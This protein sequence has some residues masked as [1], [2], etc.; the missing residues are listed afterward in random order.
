MLTALEAL[1]CG[2]ERLGGNSLRVRAASAAALP[3]KSA[4]LFLSNAG[5][6]MRPLTAA[7]ACWRRQG[8]TFELR[9]IAR[10]H[11][12]PIG[13]LVDGL[14][15]LGCQWTTSATRLPAAAAGHRRA[16]GAADRARDPGARQRL[17]QFLTALLLALPWSRART[18]RSRWSAS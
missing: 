13:D 4:D 3:V 15:Q 8:G 10:M 16:A 11:E 5:T 1:G 9:G 14:R 12:R 2:I 17:S 18:S 6:A 7:L